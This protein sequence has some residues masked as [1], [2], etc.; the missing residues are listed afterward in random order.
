MKKSLLIGG[1][2]LFMFGVLL[3]DTTGTLSNP[4]GSPASNTG[5]PG[6]LSQTCA[7]SGCHSGTT[8]ERSGLISSDIP[9]SGYVAGQT[10][11]ITVSITQSGISKWGFQISPQTP[12]G[13][14]IGTLS[15]IENT[16]TRFVGSG[17]KYITH[18]TAGNSGATGTTSW[19]LHWTAP[20]A[21]SGD[22]TFYS[23]VMAANGNGND[24]G[25]LV[26]KDNLTISED[27]ASAL[28]KI[29]YIYTPFAFPNPIEGNEI[30][31]NVPSKVNVFQLFDLNGRLWLELPNAS[32]AT[33]YVL[34][35]TKVPVGVY[36]LKMKSD[37]TEYMQRIIR[38]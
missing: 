8:S 37:T 33:S 5:S 34:D 38:R 11:T 20:A 18:T 31:L 27:P 16:R 7:R 36:L 12:S 13:A 1:A 17:N 22:V 35:I 2:M 6:D 3:L 9:A 25:D 21:G 30:T 15:L 10:Y 29:A 4:S 26:F 14:L 24:N 23:T 32:K 19:T 28:N